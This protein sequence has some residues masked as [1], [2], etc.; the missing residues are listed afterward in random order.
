M[1]SLSA[2]ASFKILS[3]SA[4]KACISERVF[5]ANSKASVIFCSLALTAER[6]GFQANYANKNKSEQNTN[7]VQNKRPKSGTTNESIFTI[8]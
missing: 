1:L 8:F 4:C 3:F 7:A 5:S 2:L 6:I